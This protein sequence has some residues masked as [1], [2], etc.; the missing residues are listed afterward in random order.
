[1]LVNVLQSNRT[2]RVHI[3]IQKDICQEG[4]VQAVMQA[5]KSHNMLPAGGE[6]GK[7]VV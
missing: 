7:L 1:M 2:K 6:P 5:K 3:D 4:L